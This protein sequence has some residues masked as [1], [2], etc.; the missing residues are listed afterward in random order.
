MTKQEKLR[1]AVL[2]RAGL[3]RGD[4]IHVRVGLL[5]AEFGLPIRHVQEELIE[6]GVQRLVEL[7]AYHQRSGVDIPLDHWESREAFFSQT[8]DGGYTRIR[9]TSR[10]AE[11]LE[12][13]AP[14]TR[15]PIGFPQT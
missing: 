10:G 12:E 7:S 15:Q 9:I 4:Q 13:L 11:L 8:D 1:A 3:Q 5:A 6:M 2:H 14:D